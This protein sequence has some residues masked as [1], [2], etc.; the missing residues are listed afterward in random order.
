MSATRDADRE[1]RFYDIS[2][3]LRPE[4]M[5]WPGVVERFERT[6]A[7][8]LEDGDAMTVSGLRL[9]AHTGTHVDAPCHFLAGGGGV[10]TLP[11]SAFLGTAVVVD[12][13]AD[14]RVVTAAVLDRLHVPPATRRL[15]AKTTNSG[16]SRS[17]SAFD[18]AY[19]AFD[20]SA[21]QWC[22]ERGLVLVGVDYLSIEPYDAHT[23]GYPVHKALLGEGV[24]VLESLDLAGV[25]AG[26]YDLAVMPLLIPGSDGAPARAVLTRRP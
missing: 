25:P 12:V 8:S 5:T 13:P 16:W 4:L 6:L 19:V 7:S 23:R 21:A 2:A 10:E 26:D 1:R 3:A 15:L 14:E 18:E 11:V 22:I 9:G 17:A 24:V 20:E